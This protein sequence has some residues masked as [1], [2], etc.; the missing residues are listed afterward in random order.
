M[1]LSMY[2][3]S[4]PV[5]I[6]FLE[7]I[8]GIIT[9]AEREFEESNVSMQDMLSARFRPDM[10]TFAEQIRQATFHATHCT[11]TL[12]GKE[13][14]ELSE[15]YSSFAGLKQRIS[16]SVAFLNGVEADSINGKEE[17]DVTYTMAGKPRPFK[18]QRLLLGHCLPNFF[19]HVTTAYDLLRN[20]GLNVGKRHFMGYAE[21]GN[22]DIP[23]S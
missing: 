21:P 5:F 13:P 12:A 11:A 8:S 2:Q 15:D 22:W 19:F 14:P 10:M 16:E 23:A 17:T 6:N 3:A 7:N 18:G 1:S 9:F 4:V 20:K